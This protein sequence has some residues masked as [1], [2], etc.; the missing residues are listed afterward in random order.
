MAPPAG[1]RARSAVSPV[2]AAASGSVPEQAGG[3]RDTESPASVPAAPTAR[4]RYDRRTGSWWWSPE[5][6][7]VLGLYRDDAEPGIESLLR[8]QHP[9]DRPRIVAALTAA[10]DQRRPF[11]LETRLVRP[12]GTRGVVLVGEPWLDGNGTV[13]AVEGICVDVSEGR[14]AAAVPDRVQ[15][16]EV[17]VDQLRCAMASRACIEQAKGILML[18]TSCG[19]QAA[20]D[21]LAHISSH[22]HRKV[23]DV[24]TAIT[25]S[26]AGGARLPEDIRR[27]VLDASPPSG[28]R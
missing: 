21:L 16:L 12:G 10:N 4:Y 19:D 22:T 6:F 20:F 17:E 2:P 8:H 28:P 1:L 27:I 23:R 18:L 3:R 7:A 24:A 13:V 11:A 25:S 14:P 26:A 9:D 5:M 15:Q